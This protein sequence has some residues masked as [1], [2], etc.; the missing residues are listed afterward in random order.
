MEMPRSG[1]GGAVTCTPSACSRSITP[2]QPEA[3][4]KA[5]CTRTTVRGAVAV[6]VSSDMR[7]PYVSSLDCSFAQPI[8]PSWAAAM[9]MAA[10]R[11]KRRRER[12]FL[13]ASGSFGVTVD[14]HDSFGKGLRGFLRQIVPNT[15]RDDPVPI[16][17]REFLGIG[18]GVRV[19][20]SIGI[21]FKGNGGHGDDRTF[22]KPLFQIVI[23]R[24]AFSQAEPPAVIMDHDADVIR[25]VEGRRAAI[26]RGIIDVPLRRSGLPNELC[27]IVPVFLVAGPAAFRGEIVLVPP[28]ELSLWRQGHLVGFRAADQITTHGDQGLAALWPECRDDVGRPRSPITTGDGSLLDLESI[29]QGDGIDSEDRLLAIPE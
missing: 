5:P 14:S 9:V 17:A 8:M 12:S 26:E 3:S 15:A 13:L 20:C 16:F 4:A 1:F 2:F 18:P 19:G 11:R 24:F 10:P 29:H 22:G 23:F 7:A 28:L 27:K 6:V 21:T 25:V